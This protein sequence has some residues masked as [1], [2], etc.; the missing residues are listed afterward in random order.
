VLLLLCVLVAP[1]V[2]AH[3]SGAA[4]DRSKSVTVI[5]TVNSVEWTSPHARLKVDATDEAGV[6][7]T[8]DFELPSPVTLTRRGWSISSLTVG[9]K[10]TVSGAP[11][12]EH[13]YIAIATG[14][15]DKNGRRLFS[16]AAGS[17]D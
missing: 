14:V 17:T 11:A 16:G 4:F 12:R 3:H 5:G 1:P 8:W 2:G 6:V 9:D 13:P 15:T 7:V 10:V